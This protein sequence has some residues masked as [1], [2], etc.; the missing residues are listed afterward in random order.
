MLLLKRAWRPATA[1]L[2]LIWMV[3]SGVFMALPQVVIG[4][5]AGKAMWEWP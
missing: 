4:P 1:R 3:Y 5:S 2:F